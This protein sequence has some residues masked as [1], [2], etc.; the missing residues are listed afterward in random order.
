MKS[1]FDDG[2]SKT[3]KRAVKYCVEN[4]IDT[5]KTAI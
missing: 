2:I 3:Q 4:I 5:P 1:D